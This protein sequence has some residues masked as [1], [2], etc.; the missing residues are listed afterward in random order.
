MD[1]NHDTAVTSAW[2]EYGILSI[3][4]KAF[5]SALHEVDQRIS[6][7]TPLPCLKEGGTLKLPWRP[8]LIYDKN[9]ESTESYG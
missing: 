2:R 3:L 5:V 7:G 8:F 9:K 6:S 1:T 4:W